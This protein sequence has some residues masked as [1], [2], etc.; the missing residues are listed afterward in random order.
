MINDHKICFITCVNDEDTYEKCLDF[1][2]RLIVPPNI[3]VEYK[4]VRGAL[5]MCAGYNTAMTESDARYKVYLHQ[6]TYIIYPYFIRRLLKLFEER[7]IGLTGVVGTTTLPNS[8]V[9]WESEYKYKYGRVIESSSGFFVENKFHIPTRISL[10]VHSKHYEEVAAI[11]G[12]LIATQYDVPWRMDIFNGWHFYDISQCMEFRR[13]GYMTVVPAQIC[14]QVV[15]DCGI[16]NNTDY[17]KYRDIF[18][19]EYAAEILK[20]QL[21]TSANSKIKACD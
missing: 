10:H 12:L 14:S 9:W 3:A 15:H 19:A 18:K 5:S 20:I 13:A 2:K 4:A 6:D 7:T 11:D 17:F 8:C 16:V 1:L 21:A